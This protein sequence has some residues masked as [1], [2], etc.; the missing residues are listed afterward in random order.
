MSEIRI[1]VLV[2]RPA[3]EVFSRLTNFREWPAWQDG[4]A[5]ASKISMGPLRAGSQVRLIR[6]GRSPS[7]GV[8]EITHMMP[9]ELFGMKG[10]T[11]NLP[12]R[13]QFALEP[14]RGGTRIR[15]IYEIS[16]SPGIISRLAT[17]I[18]LFRELHSFKSLV[19]AG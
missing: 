17:R 3:P 12:W 13:R 2:R 5:R 11:H 4:L 16:G 6:K 9:S 10:S 1:S 19:E 7:I 18:R 15:L 8:M 14:V